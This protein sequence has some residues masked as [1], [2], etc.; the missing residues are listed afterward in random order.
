MSTSHLEKSYATALLEVATHLAKTLREHKDAV[1]T[2]P[3][4]AQL[5]VPS[6]VDAKRHAQEALLK[7]IR[8]ALKVQAYPPI[9][10]SF[11]KEWVKVY[12]PEPAQRA[13]H[14]GANSALRQLQRSQIVELLVKTGVRR[15]TANQLATPIITAPEKVRE[16]ARITS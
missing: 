6:A 5:L 3:V 12:P 14:Q 7:A 16:Y 8:Q 2:P 4:I 1:P 13:I 15:D 10:F 9:T 11:N